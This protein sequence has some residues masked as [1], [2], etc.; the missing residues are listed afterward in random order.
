[1]NIE[2]RRILVTGASRGLGRALVFAF[3]EAGAAEVGPGARKPEDLEAL[4]RAAA[5]RSLKITPIRLD[6]TNDDE[7]RAASKLGVFDVLVNNAG[8]AGYGN[9][10]QMSFDDAF[11]EMNVNYFG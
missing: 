8:V 4:K 7:V 3:A 10:L 11:A 1:M 2:R 9:P 6:V 5:S